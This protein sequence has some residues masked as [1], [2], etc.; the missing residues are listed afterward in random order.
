[1]AESCCQLKQ[2]LFIVLILQ[3]LLQTVL[4]AEEIPLD[5]I[6]QPFYSKNLRVEWKLTTNSLPATVR[7]FKIVP[8]YFSQMTISE[9]MKLGGFS[10][11][12]RVWTNYNGDKLP[13]DTLCFR[14]YN[15][16]NSLAIVPAY[17]A[18]DLYAPNFDTGLPDGVP[19]EARGFDLATN[20]LDRLDIP[21]EQLIKTTD[22]RLKTWFYPGE[23]TIYPKGSEPISRRSHMGVEFRRMLDG[24]PCTVERVHIDFENQEKITRLEIQWHGIEPSKPYPIASTR[25]M[26][27][28]IK[29]GR[30]RVQSLEGPMGGRLLQPSDIKRITIIGITP[31]YTATSY[32][33]DE[34]HDDVPMSRIFPYVVLQ[35]EGEISPDDHETIWLF[36]PI[37]IGALSSISTTS[38]AYGFGIYPSNLYEKQMHSGKAAN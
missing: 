21:T 10:E 1:M 30:A 15:G 22:G 17:G 19:D 11:A 37:T 4:F 18:A 33:S 34:T 3:S 20:I 27:S 32:Y 12:N 28:W 2:K 25:K 38:T 23:T 14:N 5:Y 36:C 35:A 13:A 8:G 26:T 6:G 9:L 24:I 31:Y 29:E 16:R 7:V